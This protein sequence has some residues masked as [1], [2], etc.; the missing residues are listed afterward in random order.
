[1]CRSSAW[2]WAILGGWRWVE[3]CHRHGT[4]VIVMVTTVED[5]RVVEA[6]GFG[7]VVAQGRKLA[8]IGRNL[9]TR[10]LGR[11]APWARS[12]SSQR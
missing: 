11:S 4:K 9:A 10:L 1:M 5:A 12:T 6:T 3:A 8:A 7:A 2:A